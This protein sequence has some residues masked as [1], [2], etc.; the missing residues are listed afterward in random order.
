MIVGLGVI[1]VGGWQLS[2]ITDS[3]T[4]IHTVARSSASSTKEEAPH[5]A[6]SSL[7]APPPAPFS[8]SP[9]AESAATPVRE[10]E[11][12]PDELTA[13]ALP[14]LPQRPAADY[15]S[16]E[17][18]L[19]ERKLRVATQSD[20][21]KWLRFA[22]RDKIEERKIERAETYLT[23]SRIYVVQAPLTFPADL[24]GAHS[25]AFIVM[26]GVPTPTGS[27]GHSIVMS[28]NP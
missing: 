18:L 20:Y 15:P 1:L 26:P 14:D 10:A 19:R 9:L 27:P 13:A 17:Q 16:I 24:Y 3:L 22:A 11:Y 8:I 5:A 12:I 4:T 21:D 2:R 7:A 25:A 23:L 28:M 6:P